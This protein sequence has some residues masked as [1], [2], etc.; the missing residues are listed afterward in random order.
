MVADD[1]RCVPRA[2]TESG[3][4]TGKQRRRCER[5][6]GR[7]WARLPCCYATSKKWSRRYRRHAHYCFAPTCDARRQCCVNGQECGRAAAA[8][9]RSGGVGGPWE[10][11]RRTSRQ[12]AC[13]CAHMR[14]RVCVATA[15]VQRQLE[16]QQAPSAHSHG[17][18]DSPTCWAFRRSA[19]RVV[20]VLRSR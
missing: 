1:V 5:V 20:C 4:A 11:G 16:C 15:A 7:A 6:R 14:D 17:K 19:G 3:S 18:K 10:A 9:R 8:P 13:A 2:N 12:N